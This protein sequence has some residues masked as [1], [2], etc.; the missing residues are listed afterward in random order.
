MVMSRY[1]VA[2]LAIFAAGILDAAP[3][4]VHFVLQAPANWAQQDASGV[5][6]KSAPCEQA[7][8][9]TPAVATNAVTAFAQGATVTI[10]INE[11]IAHPGHYRVSLSTTGQSGLPADPPV[12]AGGTP[13]TPCGSTTIMSTPVYPVIA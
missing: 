8:P 11:T 2:T 6:I 4:R 10:T 3:A 7:D 5:P 9:G 1:T 12:T 13:S